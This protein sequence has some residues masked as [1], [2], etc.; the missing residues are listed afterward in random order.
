MLAYTIRLVSLRP[1]ECMRRACNTGARRRSAAAR[2]AGRCTEERRQAGA[3]MA[4][5]SVEALRVGAAE[6]RPDAAFV[7]VLTNTS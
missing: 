2:L 5:G 3:C 7:Y 4:A 1:A 6:P